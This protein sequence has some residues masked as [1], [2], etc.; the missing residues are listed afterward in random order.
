MKWFKS[1]IIK[2]L[3][4]SPSGHGTR[5]ESV[6][7]NPSQVRVLS[8]PQDHI[9]RV[10]RAVHGAGLENQ[11]AKALTG[12]NPVPSASVLLHDCFLSS[13]YNQ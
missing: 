12:S 10:V 9:G 2:R 5:L 4:E 7:G 8:P 3:E 1:D 11:W 6:R 13:R